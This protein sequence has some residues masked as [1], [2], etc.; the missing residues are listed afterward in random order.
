MTTTIHSSAIA[1]FCRLVTLGCIAHAEEVTNSVSAPKYAGRIVEQVGITPKFGQ[2]LPLDTSFV[3]AD[4]KSIRLGDCFADKPV[5]LHLVYYDCPML[6]K[7]SADGLFSTLGT[8]SLKPGQDFTIVTVSFDPREGPTLSAGARD[9]AT[10]RVG[11]EAVERGWHFL[12][13]DEASIEAV[14]NAA[15]FHYV[16]D[17]R[18]KQYAHAA[19][20]FVVTPDGTISRYLGGINY[21]PRDL[22]FS[23]FE[24]S[25]GKVGTAADQVMM[26]CYMYDPTV[27]R[28][29]LAIMT[30]LRTAGL[31]TVAT[32]T[33]AIVVMFRRDRR[34]SADSNIAGLSW[35]GSRLSDVMPGQ[36]G[37]AI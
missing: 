13:G 3:N 16:Y 26:L 7:L 19:G 28:Y 1:M 10:L 5:I 9:L 29:G 36:D 31:L 25:G 6:C 24:A 27:G 8:L 18:T 30:V 37:R 20:I 22:R 21:S 15:G 14:T 32:L 4:G 23:L 33:T 11:K 12:T 17:E 2:K 35:S 34:R